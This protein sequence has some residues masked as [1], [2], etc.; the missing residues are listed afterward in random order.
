MMP[1]PYRIVT[2]P[3][4]GKGL[5]DHQQTLDLARRFQEFRLLALKTSPNA[6]GSTYEVEVQRGLEQTFERLSNTKATQ[7]VALPREAC[8]NR[9]DLREGDLN[10]LTSSEWLGFVVLLGPQEGQ[11]S[12][13]AQK[14]PY[15][16]MTS[17]AEPRCH[18]STAEESSRL[19]FHLNGMFVRPSARKSG[20]GMRLVMSALHE[21]QRQGSVSG[22]DVYCT[23][24]VDEWND[25][26]KKLYER[27]GFEVSEKERYNVCGEDRVALRMELWRR[28]QSAEDAE[29]V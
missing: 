21:A 6:F 18:Q 24:V 9:G 23:C 22:R 27:C 7:F 4:V 28:S 20:I 19:Q 1:T 11:V 26:A 3:K 10:D 5:F 16:E 15:P 17:W 14:D 12:T 13:S 25:S 29:V 8:C 2:I